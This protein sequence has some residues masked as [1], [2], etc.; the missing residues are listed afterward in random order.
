MCLEGVPGVFE[1]LFEYILLRS[2]RLIDA[3]SVLPC[4]LEMPPTGVVYLS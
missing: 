2:E 4:G 1:Y 3:T